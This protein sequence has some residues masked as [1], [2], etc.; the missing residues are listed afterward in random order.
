MKG[1]YERKVSSSDN[2]TKTKIIFQ[3]YQSNQNF[4]FILSSFFV[5]IHVVFKNYWQV[6]RK[7]IKERN[8]ALYCLKAGSDS[9]QTTL[10]G[11]DERSLNKYGCVINISQFP[12][13]SYNLHRTNCYLRETRKSQ[14]HQSFYPVKGENIFPR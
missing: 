9:L 7:G 3:Q 8:E 4:L 14:G 1:T 6:K 5:P 12:N 2:C 10:T 11:S 13:Q